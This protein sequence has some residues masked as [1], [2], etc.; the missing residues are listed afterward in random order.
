[1]AANGCK[2][3]SFVFHPGGR[4]HRTRKVIGSSECATSLS[5]VRSHPEIPMLHAVHDAIGWNP[6]RGSTLRECEGALQTW[7]QA[8]RTATRW[9]WRWCLWGFPLCFFEPTSEQMYKIDT[10]YIHTAFF[11][12]GKNVVLCLFVTGHS[13]VYL[14]ERILCTVF[15]ICINILYTHHRLHPQGTGQP[16]VS[17][18]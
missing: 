5:D 1:M 11:I 4:H 16:D 8:V 6:H 17:T 3:S 9:S 13:V 15:P 7:R 2:S 10:A 12:Y 18:R 14:E